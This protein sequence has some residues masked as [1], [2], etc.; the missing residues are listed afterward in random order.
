[1]TPELVAELIARRESPTLDFKGEQYD[2][3][4]DGNL[5]LAKDLMAIANGLAP[6]SAPGYILIGVDT[7]TDQTG[8]VVGVNPTVHLDDAAMH[9]K[10]NHILNRCPHFQYAP[11][12]IDG[13]SVGVFEIRP[14]GRP[15][16]PL[17]TSGRKHRLSRFEARIRVGS[18][19]D[20]A[21]P[22]QIQSWARED[23]AESRD[24]RRV[25]IEIREAQLV[26]RPGLS[27]VKG[28]F[29]K[30]RESG[31]D[32][33][34]H[35]VSVHN[36]GESRFSVVSFVQTWRL[37]EAFYAQVADKEHQRASA[38]LVLR[39]APDVPV[40]VPPGGQVALEVSL[41]AAELVEYIASACD[42]HIASTIWYEWVDDGEIVVE[43]RGATGRP[44][45]ARAVFDMEQLRASIEQ[46]N[47]QEIAVRRALSRLNQ[48]R[49]P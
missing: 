23:D 8:R 31:D 47:E 45:E 39:R 25:E 44:G 21:S 32:Q 4:E 17:R 6:G 3:D 9:Q 7:E 10:V 14:G 2:W 26:I 37:S 11:I 46:A 36:L 30:D 38:D 12:E 13:Q 34:I 33:I 41:S 40:S 22:E 43:C 5:E 35:E 20:V 1:M 19:T 18:S 42:L 29:F 28:D 49:R 48:Q 24:L 16:Y 15:F 27:I